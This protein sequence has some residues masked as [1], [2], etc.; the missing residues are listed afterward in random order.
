[1]KLRMEPILFASV[2]SVVLG[3]KQC[4]DQRKCVPMVD[5]PEFQPLAGQSVR[6]WPL[7][8]RNEFKTHFC[9]REQRPTGSILTVCCN[10]DDSIQ[11]GRKSKRDLHLQRCGR[12]SEFRLPKSGVA[13]VFMFPWM[14]LLGGENDEFH[15]TGSLITESFVLTAAHCNRR[16]I[17]FARVGETD[18]S[19]AVDCFDFA[20][21]KDCADPPQDIPVALVITHPSYDFRTKK[22]D[23]ALIKLTK[24][25]QLNDNVQPICLP[26]PEL[27]PT[28]LPVRMM[29]PGWGHTEKRN[30]TSRQ[31]RYTSLPIVEPHQCQ[32]AYS[33]LTDDFTV[34]ES[35]VC[36]GQENHLTDNCEGES[37]GPLQ[38][39]VKRAFVIHGVGSLIA[40]CGEETSTSVYTKVS[41]YL[42]WIVDNIE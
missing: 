29:A 37:G 9:G 32:Q 23:I 7:A 15:C 13:T 14:A 36:T 34:D 19:T 39:F 38:Y 1:M 20:G 41:H 11:P 31:L 18:L 21:E 4:S 12:S 28:K 30:E 42:D 26:L 2:L 27:L 35:Q 24:P 8:V 10:V 25:V 3:Q 5:C 16:K 33:H 40:S 17:N 22:N 6:T